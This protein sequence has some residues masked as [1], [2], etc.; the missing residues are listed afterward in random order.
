MGDVVT[1]DQAYTIEV[2]LALIEMF[3][4]EWQM[5]YLE[6]P[7]H[8]LSACMFLLVSSLEGMRGFEV[9]WTNLA[10]LCYDLSYCKAAKDDTAVS[11]LIVGCFKAQHG[12]LDAI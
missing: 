10:S 1:Q 4:Q 5:I 6:I 2:L 8:S 9:V 7:L 12:V 3:E 11:W